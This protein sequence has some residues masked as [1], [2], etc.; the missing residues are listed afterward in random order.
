MFL[1]LLNPSEEEMKIDGNANNRNVVWQGLVAGLVG[2]LAEVIWITVLTRAGETPEVARGITAA[3]TTEF[4][5]LTYGPLLGLTIHF[6]LA[7]AL[8]VAM[9]LI[10]IR[11]LGR[12][13][14]N[15]G[16][17]IFAVATLCFVWTV[18]FHVVLPI[19][20]PEFLK[21]VPSEI[22]LSSKI[23]FALGFLSAWQLIDRRWRLIPSFGK[24]QERE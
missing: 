14:L 12:S 24:L 5:V 22:G 13:F 8:G 18:N 6:I 19:I 4:A 9:G 7:G 15:W 23:I 1:Q 16:G 20:S 17:T 21:L 3:I 11:F 10:W 2:G